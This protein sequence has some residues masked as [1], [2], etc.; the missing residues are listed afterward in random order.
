MKFWCPTSVIWIEKQGKISV[1]F[2][3]G[4][5]YQCRRWLWP[6]K[7]REGCSEVKSWSKWQTLV[8]KFVVSLVTS[9]GLVDGVGEKE[10]RKW[11]NVV[12]VQIPTAE[13]YFP[14][15]RCISRPQ[16]C[17][18]KLCPL[19]FPTPGW[20]QELITDGFIA[21]KAGKGRQK[22]RE[23]EISRKGAESHWFNL[24][25]S[26]NIIVPLGGR[27]HTGVLSLGSDKECL[28][29]GPRRVHT[30]KRC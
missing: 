27:Q 30:V 29:W 20:R 28:P 1:I 10:T 8:S 24:F 3:A 23:W 2:A 26:S 22:M 6:S 5:P 13:V 21:R 4:I 14:T 9:P 19:S 16:G 12:F 18:F 15:Q 7:K 25:R 11:G 17:I